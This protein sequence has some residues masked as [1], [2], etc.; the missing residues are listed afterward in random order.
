MLHYAQVQVKYDTQELYRKGKTVKEV[1]NT[2]EESTGHKELSF[3][4]TGWLNLGPGNWLQ[5][6]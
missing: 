1:V 5:D 2:K 6:E 4:Q 3:S